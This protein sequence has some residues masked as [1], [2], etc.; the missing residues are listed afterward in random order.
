M[1]GLDD[2]R[3]TS[4]DTFLQGRP[5]IQYATPGSPNYA[6]LRATYMLD[7]PAVPF[8]I[9][10]PQNAEDV[11][12]IV[13]FGKANGLSLV[14]RSGGNSLFWKSMVHDALIIDMRDIAYVTINEPK[15]LARLGGG[16]HLGDLADHLTKEGLATAIGTIPFVG[17]IGWST[18]GGYGPFS[19][20]Y[21]LGCDNIVG[22]KIVNCKGEVVEADKDMLKGIRGAGGAFG[23]IVELT[24]KTYQLKNVSLV[25]SNSA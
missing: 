20:Q 5:H 18:F 15:T 10:R 23:P 3:L 9:V 2:P 6:A 21:G 25:D 16:I 11:A 4:L 19:A 1:G 12:A 13:R 14:V 24:V 22:A 17:F 8:A 7:N